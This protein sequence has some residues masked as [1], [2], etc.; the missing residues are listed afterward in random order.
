MSVVC[1]RIGA[2]RLALALMLGLLAVSGYVVAPILF[3]EAGSRTLA[4][5]LAGDI[6]HIVNRGVIFLAAAVMV[7]WLRMGGARIGW[8]RWALLLTVVVMVAANAFGVA[9]LI[10]DLKTQAGPIDQLAADDPQRQQFALWHGVSA[11]LHLIATLAAAVLV[12][13]RPEP[14]PEA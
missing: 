12:A 7:F 13:I 11:I 14:E 4:G 8:L 10:A 2:V 6:F 3:A 1:F 5:A 9:P